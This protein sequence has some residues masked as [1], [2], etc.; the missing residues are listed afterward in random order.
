AVGVDPTN[1]DHVLVGGSYCGARS[2]DGGD[3]WENI[4]HWLPQFGGST[5]DGLLPYVHADWHAIA[6][7]RAGIGVFTVV[8]SDGGVFFSNN[9]F[10]ERFPTRVRWVP[11]NQGIVT[12]QF[13]SLASGDPIAGDDYLVFGGLQDNGTR[14]RDTAAASS[15]ST[16]NQ[17]LGG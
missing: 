17:V 7:V 15:P 5:N 10:M 2:M 1:S 3:T 13:Y 8:G 4:S 6:V 12:H 16:F 11:R 14:F 9:L